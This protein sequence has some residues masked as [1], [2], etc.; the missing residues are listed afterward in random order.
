MK[1]EQD[2][3][4]NINKSTAHKIIIF[5]QKPWFLP[6][7]F[8]EAKEQKAKWC[9]EKEKTWEEQSNI[10]VYWYYVRSIKIIWNHACHY[11]LLIHILWLYHIWIEKSSAMCIQCLMELVIF[12]LLNCIH[13]HV[14]FIL[15]V[16]VPFRKSK[17]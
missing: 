16:I 11:R 15:F 17:M 3:K 2:N 6:W 14:C 12:L 5:R 10:G 7:H 4:M 9:T 1:V 13:S 8:L